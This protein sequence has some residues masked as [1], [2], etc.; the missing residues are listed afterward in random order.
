MGKMKQQRIFS[1]VMPL[2]ENH[3]RPSWFRDPR[4]ASSPY[5]DL[6]LDRDETV[7]GLS[8]GTGA[9]S[10]PENDA[11]SA[12]VSLSLTGF[13]DDLAQQ[14]TFIQPG[15]FIMGS[16]EH[17]PGRSDDEA[18]HRVTL[19]HGFFLA[20]YLVTRALWR[21][22]MEGTPV[23]ADPGPQLPASEVSWNE[24]LRF[25]DRLNRL[26]GLCYRLPTEAEWEYACRAGS[27]TA[28]CNGHIESLHCGRD[29]YLDQVGWYCGNSERRL[30]RVGT[31]VPN[32]W[33]LYDMHGNLWE[34]C[35]DW[36]AP[37]PEGDQADPGGPRSGAVKVVR[38]GSWFS[39][40][41]NCRS[42]KRFFWTP[43]SGSDMIGFRLARDP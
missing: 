14:L 41:K 24:C 12:P 16:P 11:T 13:L 23:A 26:S 18:E 8:P 20:P 25:I 35:Q 34:W 27:V 19:S 38:G 15:S 39:V 1:K 9:T 36:Y 10:E 31:K 17:E 21:T 42:A 37:Y 43:S 4:E 2:R 22:V 7:T 3:G 6:D 40:A 32:E 33:G 5:T 30:H 29:E 28:F